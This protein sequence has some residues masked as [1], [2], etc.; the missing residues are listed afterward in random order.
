M[1]FMATRKSVTLRTDPCGS[2][3]SKVIEEFYTTFSVV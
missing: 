2:P 3:F 1:L